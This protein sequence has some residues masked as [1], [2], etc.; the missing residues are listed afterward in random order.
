MPWNGVSPSQTFGRTDGTRTG[1][2]VWQQASAAS[3]PIDSPD[4][5][6]HDQDIASGLN[7]AIKKDGG[8]TATGNLPMG[9][10][11]HTNVG[12][13]SASTD[14]ARFSDLQNAKG[15]YV[16]TVGGSADAI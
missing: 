7:L 13:A 15:I 8:N 2:T 10:F 9:G 5:D 12:A 6:T 14:Y 11:R 16:P 1:T 3:V 4:H